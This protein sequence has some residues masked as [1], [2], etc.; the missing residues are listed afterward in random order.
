MAPPASLRR[1]V[2]AT[3]RTEFDAGAERVA[4]ALARRLGVDLHVVMPLASNPEYVGTEPEIA[5]QAEQQAAAALAALREQ[6]R[7][8]GVLASPIVR[9]GEVLWREIVEGA[10]LAHADLLVTRRVGRRGL[11]A[12]LLVGEMVSQVAAHATCPMMMVPA[13]ADRLW[14]E[15]VLVSRAVPG[16]PAES[17]AT[18]LAAAASAVLDVH[19]G[20]PGALA[21]LARPRD[22]VVIEAAPGQSASGRLDMAIE[23]LVGAVSCPAVVVR[24]AAGGAQP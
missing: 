11:L 7:A 17:V 5:L 21:V 14:S 13:T 6:A 16:G 1:L 3:E 24:S 18:M 15:R 22:L 4:I 8:G 10:R 20:D 23:D 2:L 9:R 12:R 19:A